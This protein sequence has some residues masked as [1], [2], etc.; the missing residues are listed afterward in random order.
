MAPALYC[1]EGKSLKPHL[2]DRV[3]LALLVEI[4]PL[5]D[6]ETHVLIK[7]QGLLVLLV[8]RDFL[9]AKVL[10]T[11][12]KQLPAQP[13]PAFVRV[14]KKHLQFLILNAHKCDG[15][16][17]VIPGDDQMGNTLHRMGT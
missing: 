9:N 4:H 12:L 2:E 7:A 17:C 1:E 10:H 11:M 13:F 15:G 8:D 6:A 16:A 14:Q 3:G 5:V